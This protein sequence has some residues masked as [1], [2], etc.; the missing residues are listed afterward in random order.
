MNAKKTYPSFRSAVG[1]LTFVS[2]AAALCGLVLPVQAQDAEAP[3]EE[4]VVKGFK[5]S[6]SVALDIKRESTGQ[7]DAIVAEDIAD[8]P[9]LNLAEALQRIPGVAITRDNGEGRTITVRG[10]SG[11]YTKTRINGMESRAG[12]NTNNGRATDFSMFASELFNSIVVH[13]TAA[14]ELDDGSIGAVV[15]LNTARPFDYDEG[16]TFLLGGQANYNDL[17]EENAPRFTGLFAYNDPEGLFG[18]SASL[19]VS[20]HDTWTTTGNTVRWQQSTFASV[21]GV[22]CAANPAD[23]GCAEVTDAFHARIP[24]YGDNRI[25]R[26]RTGATLGLQFAPTDRTEITIDGLFATYDATNDFKTIEVLFRGNEGGMDVTDYTIQSN[27]DNYGRPNDTIIAMDVDNA[28]V[29]SETYHQESESEFQQISAAFTHDVSDRFRINGLFGKADSEG[30]LPV[31]TTLMYD[32]RDYMGFSYDY[33]SSTEYPTLAYNGPDVSDGTIFSLTTVRDQ[34]HT[35]MTGNTVVDFN[36]EADIA[37]NHTITAGVNYKKFTMDTEQHRR[38]GDSCG[39]GLF[40]CDLDDDGTDDIIGAPG[41]A[42]LSEQFTYDGRTGPGSTTTWA[43]PS[44]E[45]WTD[46]LGY[47]DVPLREDQGRIR[48]V[49]EENLGYFVQLAGEFSVGANDMRLLYDFGVRYVETDQISSGYNSGQ[50][51]T[52]KRD[53]YSDTLP[54]L[55]LALW[56]TDELVI[57]ASAARVL[58]RPSLSQLSP[59]GSVNSFSNLRVS[60]QNPELEPIRADSIDLSAEWYFA[61]D[62]VLSLALF[63]KDIESFPVN[64]IL[65]DVTYA[66]SGL[67]YSLIDPTSAI[68]NNPEGGPLD[69]CNPA[70]GGTGCWEV[71]TLIN[72]PG[73]D[74]TGWELSF[75]APFSSLFGDDL[76]AVLN[77]MGVIAN[78]TYVDSTVPYTWNGNSIKERLVGLSNDSYNAT[79]YYEDDKFGARISVAH[80]SDYLE[81]SNPD[82]NDNLWQFVEP[83]TWVDFASSYAVNENLQLVFEV[84]NLTDEPHDVLVDINAE[85]RERFEHTGRNY[86]I[87][88]RYV[89]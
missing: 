85:R 82:R 12:T 50:W 88:A 41:T 2:L 32:D 67:P 71:A 78:Y 57:R 34:V 89:F 28:W 76:P 19:A 7:V 58:A 86:V 45:G 60:F 22:D 54:S 47:Y 37:D 52:W 65:H 72:G 40:D 80:R 68:V 26:E 39:L 51:I 24:R 18:V 31:N 59:G 55:N 8:F 16:M 4:I 6:L 61:E 20:E 79:L 73:A 49:E 23:A 36:F 13:K 14:A 42:A 46:F 35:T 83:K 69:A 38:D 77:N 30:H 44:L 9:D 21:L 70:N 17:S 15:D 64:Q 81:N 1:R 11:L 27:P 53:T 5:G 75:Q 10:L 3:M 48:Q 87:G 63:D 66:S 74:V 62:S 33:S 84:T 56:A 25:H 43:A 29:R